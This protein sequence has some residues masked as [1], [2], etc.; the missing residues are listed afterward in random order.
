MRP[1]GVLSPHPLVHQ[2]L[3][4]APFSDLLT[5]HADLD[6]ALAALAA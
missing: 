3:A 6:A 4:R 5:V 2:A 1:L